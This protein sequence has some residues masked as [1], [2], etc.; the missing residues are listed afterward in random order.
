MANVDT[1]LGWN[2]E[3]AYLR[4]QAAEP[5]ATLSEFGGASWPGQPIPGVGESPTAD[6]VVVNG[7][8]VGRFALGNY[9]DAAENPGSVLAFFY[10]NNYITY[11]SATPNQKVYGAYV[12]G[13]GAHWN[14]SA[15]NPTTLTNTIVVDGVTFYY[16][17]LY[18]IYIQDYSSDINVPRF[19]SVADAA[20]TVTVL[21][22]Q[23]SKLNA[24]YAV[25]C[26]AK[27][28]S[29]AGDTITSPVLISSD[30]DAVVISDD[31]V[32]P[33]TGAMTMSQLYD[34]MRFYM[35]FLNLRD[36]EF[37]NVLVPTADMTQAGAA[38][39][40]K[41][42]KLIASD[43]YA[44][45]VVTETVDP[46]EDFDHTEEDAGETDPDPEDDDIEEPTVPSL[47]F[48]ATGLC[49]IYRADLIALNQ[50]ASYMWTDTTFL[51]TLVNHAIQLIENPM[52]AII[53]LCLVPVEPPAFSVGA[54]ESVSVMYIPTPAAMWPV[55]NQFARVDCGFLTLKE[56]YGSALDY[57]PYTKVSC[58]LPYIGFVD[59]DTD[60]VMG[61]TLQ[62]IYRID[63]VTGV[64]VAMIKVND[65]I[66]YQFTGHC[67]I[68]MPLSSAD[69]STVIG[70][71]LQA[72]KLV[73]GTAAMAAGA[74]EVGGM[75]LDAPAITS[76]GKSTKVTVEDR[77]SEKTG[78]KLTPSTSTTETTR[79]SAKLSSGELIKRA[80]ANTVGA[81][82]N[83]KFG[84]EHSGGFSGNSGYLGVRRPFIIVKRPRIANPEQY[85]Q[86]NGRPSMVYL[87]LGSCT[88]Y[89]EV[90]SVQLTGLSATNDEMSEIATLLKAGVI[91]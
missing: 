38:Q 58:F 64:C 39:P 81:I 79:E 24:G 77:F 34:G 78:R 91:L 85:G 1:G 90:Q 12:D 13:S 89:T 49:R 7:I 70:A 37:T 10:K 32:N 25:C 74:P 31:G 54:A 52:D 40:V 33:V 22:A 69:F 87:N 2:A 56:T 88:G 28:L 80:S 19:S 59:L 63:V 41:A 75:L 86:Y 60:E 29:L 43:S 45:I 6:M 82:M 44:H 62:V 42:F 4:S 46:Y 76:G 21:T 73:A 26:L 23:Y 8:R 55:T 11:L 65:D 67:A 83:S 48:A 72:G 57:N 9:Y 30:P 47:S 14:I 35:T 51:Q 5:L 53:S 84:I 36:K 61:K 16:A 66:M 3:G 50:L 68:Q 20:A 17:D 27:W 71:L 15:L 18:H